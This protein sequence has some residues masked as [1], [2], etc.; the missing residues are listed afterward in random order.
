MGD[1]CDNC[2]ADAN[3]GQQDSDRDDIGNIC[4]GCPVDSFNDADG[5]GLCANDDNCPLVANPNQEDMDSD[6]HGDRCDSC[7]LYPNPAQFDSDGDGQGN[8]CDPCPFDQFNDLDRDGFCANEDNCSDLANPGQED[9]DQDGVG[10]SCDNCPAEAN[11]GQQDEDLDGIGDACDLCSSPDDFDCDGVARGDNCPLI[12]NEDQA[13]ADDDPFGDACDHCPA[14]YSLFNIDTDRDG[15]GDVCDN[16]VTQPN[17]D[18]LD[19]DRSRLDQWAVS[20]VASSEW[21]DT[22]WSAAQATGAPELAGCDSVE[23]N[24]SPLAGGTDA[25]WLELS[26]PT[27]VRAMGV[28]VFESGIQQGFV[29]RIDL[30]D[31]GGQ[32]HTV[33]SGTD[34]TE[35]GGELARFW[36]P[37]TDLVDGVIVY[38]Q[39]AEWE[40][41]DAVELIGVGDELAPDGVGDICDR[42]PRIP[43]PHADDD[44]DN[45]GNDCDCAPN[46][47]SARPPAEV[48]GLLID[49]PSPGTARLSWSD[50]AGADSFAVTRTLLSTLSADSYGSCL[51]SDLSIRMF[52]DEETPTAGDG[53]GYLVHGVDSVC[54]PGTLGF[55]SSGAERRNTDARACP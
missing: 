55:T 5:D 10:D 35:C 8:A 32:L 37:T 7:P 1:P 4:D 51:A 19:S 40:E 38:T 53:F 36:T 21:S 33:W 25:E 18:Q 50:A 22:A 29:T 30:R 54:G 20:A 9:S 26:Y 45:V 17:P 46:D 41:I 44:S 49:A 23:T 47:P 13:N 3:P 52:E 11:P 14:V 12:P 39:V 27:A 43:G 28:R 6:G 15:V 16:C 48:P 24:W 42:C 2:P 34:P 31:T